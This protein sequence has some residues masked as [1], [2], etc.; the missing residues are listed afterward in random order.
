MFAIALVIG[1]FGLMSLFGFVI[2]LFNTITEWLPVAFAH[3]VAAV[4]V[5]FGCCLIIASI[6]WLLRP[7]YKRFERFFSIIGKVFY[8]T[9]IFPVVAFAVFF[10]YIFPF[11]M[12][13]SI[14]DS[15]LWGT[16]PFVICTL[17]L[18][19]GLWEKWKKKTV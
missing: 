9:C 13:G 7:L 19:Y 16:I 11:V 2:Y 17:T 3:T 15:H 10:I 4:T 6:Y 12:V 1:G 8:Y 5:F 18:A 14:A